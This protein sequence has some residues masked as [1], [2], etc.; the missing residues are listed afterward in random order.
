M[1]FDYCKK[2]TSRSW[3]YAK[4]NPMVIAGWIFLIL[5]IA[6][7]GWYINYK[8]I[9]NADDLVYP[10]L[11]E[12][13]NISDVLFP[14]EHS[15]LLKFP[16]FGLQAILPYDLLFLSLAN[17]GLHFLTFILIAV[18][19][20]KMFPKNL[21]PVIL[22]LISL[23][24]ISS[25]GFVSMMMG[26]TIRNIEY[27]IAMCFM[28]VISAILLEKIKTKR[29]LFL[30]ISCIVLYSITV[31][32]DSFFIYTFTL[33]ASVLTG[34]YYLIQGKLKP[35]K[36]ILYALGVIIG[37]TVFALLLRKLISITGAQLY[38]ANEFIPHIIPADH[39]WPS[40]VGTA[41]SMLDRLGANIFGQRISPR[42]AIIFF[43]FGLIILSLLGIYLI[44]KSSKKIISK[45]DVRLMSIYSIILSAI[46]I[47]FVF[48][49]SDLAI[50]SSGAIIENTRYLSFL[51]IASIISILYLFTIIKYQ[52]FSDAVRRITP[53]IIVC[54][55][56]LGIPLLRSINSREIYRP[57]VDY[58]RSIID[59][60][61]DNDIDVAISGYWNSSTIRFW[62]NNE[63]MS[64]SVTHCDI[65]DP[66]INN[67]E[68][69]YSPSK[70]AGRSALI[71]TRTGPDTMSWQCPDSVLENTYGKP[72]SKVELSSPAASFVNE[73]WIYNYDLR[74]V[75]EKKTHLIF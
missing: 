64:A 39:L 58:T 44:V 18:V 8:I 10:Y 69:W 22:F 28:I 27:P 53:I 40:I 17:I 73:I 32:G 33:A 35:S 5:A 24:L 13:L 60:L 71:V 66:R 47:S 19:M 3:I 11:F 31:G 37:S 51:P 41:E 65:P 68:S 46:I 7:S 50:G 30:A 36:Q 52:E 38:T 54:V 42:N 15:N 67:K 74:S 16:L 61:R 43:N 29:R 12:H 55:I 57:T 34:L 70:E 49:V 63:I 14:S 21:A 59:I 20:V 48:I 62:S 6:Y 9:T 26:N 25:P 56:I 2:I 45:K 4:N 23:L 72:S 1:I 75:I